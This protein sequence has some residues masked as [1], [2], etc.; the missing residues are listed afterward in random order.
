MCVRFKRAKDIAVIG[1]LHEFSF[2]CRDNRLSVMGDYAINK[3]GDRFY[4]VF[5]E[6]H[7]VGRM[8]DEIIDNYSHVSIGEEFERYSRI[9][10]SAKQRKRK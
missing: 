7:L 3:N 2:Y 9:S 10:E 8:F 1:S 4:L 6:K 5:K